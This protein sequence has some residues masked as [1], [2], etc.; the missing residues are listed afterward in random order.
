MCYFST[1]VDFQDGM[2]V[3]SRKLYRGKSK[4]LAINAARRWARIGVEPEGATVSI[5]NSEGATVGRGTRKE[6]GISWELR[7]F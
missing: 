1:F 6:K 5:L 7:R 2:I 4:G 3:H